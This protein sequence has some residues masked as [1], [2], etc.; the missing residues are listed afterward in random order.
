[1][2]IASNDPLYFL[3]HLSLLV[4]FKEGD[5][6][7]FIFILIERF[8]RVIN[9]NL[10]LWKF[11]LF[12]E[13]GRS[14]QTRLLPCVHPFIIFYLFCLLFSQFLLLF[15]VLLVLVL[16]SDN[17]IFLIFV[18]DF[19]LFVLTYQFFHFLICEYSATG[20]WFVVKAGVR[21][22]IWVIFLQFPHHIAVGW[23]VGI[24]ENVDENFMGFGWVLADELFSLR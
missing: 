18:L 21:N 19:E 12:Y 14:E 24:F 2:K 3:L 23:A 1:M 11:I 6:E 10:Y 13:F 20:F 17:F 5:V 4:S 8:H 16:K 9:F 15:L 7:L 22:K